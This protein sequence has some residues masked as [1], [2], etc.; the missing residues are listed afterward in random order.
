MSSYLEY[1]SCAAGGGSGGVGGDV[2]GFAPKFCRADARP[3][4]L[5]PAFPLGSGDGAFVSCLP[6]AT[7]RP[8][9]SPPVAPAQPPGPQPS[10]SRYAPCT[11]EGAYERGAAPASAAEYSF[12]GSGPAF[13]F[14]GALGRAADDSGPHV[15]YA[16]SAV[17]SGGGSFLLSGQVDFAAF[18]EPGPFP[19]CLKE[20]VDGHPGPFQTV[21]PAPGACPKPASPTS[22]LPAAHSTFEW[23][24]VKRNAPKKSKEVGAAGEAPGVQGAASSVK[25]WESVATEPWRE[26]LPLSGQSP[27]SENAPGAEKIRTEA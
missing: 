9:P 7:A 26:L 8:T 12:L 3:V 25:S 16:T 17:F 5:Q 4:A 6:L 22:G 24:K 21:S 19:A 20:P 23:M 10:A 18:A 11:L 27:G 2:L 15:H 1:V 14:P 13:D